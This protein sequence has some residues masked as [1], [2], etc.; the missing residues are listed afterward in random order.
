MKLSLSATTHRPVFCSMPS[1]DTETQVNLMLETDF[2]KH[3][4]HWF[5]FSTCF[6][7]QVSSGHQVLEGFGEVRAHVQDFHHVLRRQLSNLA[8][9]F[10]E[11]QLY[12]HQPGLQAF[13]RA[14]VFTSENKQGVFNK[15]GLFECKN[16]SRQWQQHAFNF[17]QEDDVCFR[18]SFRADLLLIMNSRKRQILRAR[19]GNSP[20]KLNGNLR[21]F[22]LKS[23]KCSG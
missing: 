16:K 10:I 9:A 13:L 19:S 18:L 21:S 20:Q 22:K 6:G 7:V 8:A 2:H 4:Q 15:R 1:P 3:V 11:G 23:T 17:R 5:G 14:Q 12:R